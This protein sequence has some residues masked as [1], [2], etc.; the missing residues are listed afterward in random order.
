MENVYS[1]FRLSSQIFRHSDDFLAN[2]GENSWVIGV[3]IVLLASLLI[4]VLLLASLFYFCPP[5]CCGS[6]IC[7]RR[8]DSPIVSTS[9]GLLHVVAGLT[10]FASIPAF[11]GVHTVFAALLL[12]SFLKLLAFL[13]LWVVKRV[14]SSLMLLVT[15]VTVV[16]CFTAVACTRLWQA[17]LLMLVS[18]MFLIVSCSS[19]F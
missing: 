14:L 9:V 17:F 16:A 13:L 7:C 10:V 2:F 15:G 6:A 8:C 5:C 4:I 18:V 19:L 12:L 11:D 3:H 1:F